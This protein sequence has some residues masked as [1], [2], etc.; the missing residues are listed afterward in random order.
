M[1]PRLHTVFLLKATVARGSAVNERLMYACCSLA[2]K[3]LLEH[4]SG[5]RARGCRLPRGLGF[6]AA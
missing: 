3:V 2:F 1:A 4:A 5:H 6:A